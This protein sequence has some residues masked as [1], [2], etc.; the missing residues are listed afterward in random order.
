MSRPVAIPYSQTDV[1]DFLCSLGQ[2]LEE[3]TGGSIPESSRVYACQAIEQHPGTR[4]VYGLHV[5]NFVG[6]SLCHFTNFVRQL[7]ESSTIVSIDPNLPHRGIHHPMDSVIRCLNRYGL[8]GNSLILT[9]YSLEKSVS[10][11]G[12]PVAD[13][14]PGVEFSREQS[15]ENQ[16]PQLV[17]ILPASFDFAVIDS[18]HEERYLTSEIEAIGRL[19]KTGGLLIL[20][21]VD[22]DEL[23]KVYRGIDLARYDN[24]GTD[25]RIGLL[26]KKPETVRSGSVVE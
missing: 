21:D 1:L 10:N 18:N 24:L 15:C 16:L 26:R 17:R 25:G 20:D 13:Y 22:W 6:V 12:V 7:D 2:D 8:Q 5:G 14:D 9:G 19:L 11:D 23:G 3:V 4:P